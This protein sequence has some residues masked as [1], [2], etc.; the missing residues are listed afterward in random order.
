M[1]NKKSLKTSKNKY[2]DV[3]QNMKM[4]ISANTTSTKAHI[5][6]KKSNLTDN[7]TQSSSNNFSQPSTNTDLNNT[8]DIPNQNIQ[9]V[10]NY[11][12]ATF[13]KGLYIIFYIMRIY[14]ASI[15][16]N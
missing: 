10:E 5:S 2:V 7:A 13:P 4:N 9:H 6:T 12:D 3:K 15:Y 8:A 16:F 1:K 11:Q 14:T